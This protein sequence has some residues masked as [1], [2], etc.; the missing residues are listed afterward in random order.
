[1]NAAALSSA[2]TCIFFIFLIL[3]FLYGL[4][5]GFSKSLTRFFIVIAVAVATFF[6]V[7]AISNALLSADISSWGLEVEGV[8]VKNLQQFIVEFLSNIEQVNELMNASPTFTSFI[9]VVPQILLNIAL[10]IVLFLLIKM[11]SMIIYWIL[12]AILFPKKKM[13]GKNKHRFVGGIIGAVQG[14]FVAVVVLLPMFG[15]I[16]LSTEA[17]TAINQSETQIAQMATTTDPSA[18][19]NT[20]DVIEVIDEYSSALANNGIY[21]VMNG[22]G[23]IKLSNNIFDELTTVKVQTPDST[24]EYKLTTEAV[25]ISR[26]Y[27]Y[28]SLVTESEFNIGNNEFINKIVLLVDTAKESPL[29]SD[30]VC[31]IVNEAATRWTDTNIPNR[32]DRV[33]LGIAAPDLQDSDLNNIL[34]T[35]LG[36]LKNA[37]KDTVH[38]SLVGIL[39]VAQLANTTKDI[40]TELGDG[41]SNI[42]SENLEELF[43]NIVSN[44]LV[45]SLV[46][47]VLTED[48]L[49]ESFGLD[50][51]TAEMVS[52]IVNDIASADPE[53]I[54]NE[55]EA[56]KELFSLSEKI[57]TNQEGQINLTTPDENGNTPADTL[58]DAI[59]DSTIIK[60]FIVDKI[61]E[62][63]EAGQ[64]NI[65]QQLNIAGSVDEET[66]TAISNKISE[67]VQA[68]TIDQSTVEAFEKI[69]GITIPTEPEVNE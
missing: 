61:N 48:K 39:K 7:P 20:N 42:S 43:D 67:K 58:V 26:L 5:R 40:V 53:T 56:T 38:E 44:D 13:A 27:P 50:Q 14:L 49:K 59:A 15:I 21:K 2:L 17:K 22:I 51:G 55:V 30:I 12:S 36:K 41:L 16:N 32:Q 46:T 10:F 35:E 52:G 31:E 3:G 18:D 24:K 64:E 25:E 47:E 9:Q 11:L 65:I 62:E 34:D 6:I 60:D 54:K 4:W 68:G 45:Q 23:I 66:K 8:A 63:T 69:F 33:F 28:I 1:M 37:N 19:Q 29:L 57:T